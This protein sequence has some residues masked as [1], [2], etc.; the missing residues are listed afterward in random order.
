MM[1]E[2]LKQNEG[3]ELLTLWRNW[4]GGISCSYTQKL[5]NAKDLILLSEDIAN[6]LFYQGLRRG[7]IVAL[8]LSNSVGFPVIL[9][10]T[11]MIGCNPLLLHVSTPKN[12]IEKLAKNIPIRWIIHD[13]FVG[14][15]RLNRSDFKKIGTIFLDSLE[16]V[17]F[18][19]SDSRDTSEHNIYAESVIFHPTSGTYGMPQICMRNQKVTIAEAENYTIT[20]K[21][22]NKIRI[23]ITTPLSHAYA[24][25][26][27]L[28]S[29]IL[30]HSIL[31]VS[32]EFNPK[33]LLRWERE[34]P[35]DFLTIVPSMIKSLIYLKKFDS[36][37]QLPKVVFYAGTRCDESII[38]DFEQ[39]FGSTLYTIYGSTETGAI[40]TNKIDN[41][42]RFGVGTVLNNVQVK[43]LNIKKY[44]DLGKEIGEIYVKSSSMMQGYIHNTSYNDIKYFPT[45]DIGYL[46]SNQNVHL[47]GRIRDVINI[48]GIK[49]DPVEIENVLFTYPNIIDCAVYPGKSKAG[50]EIILAALTTDKEELDLEDVKKFCYQ[51]LNTHKIPSTFFI[52]KEIPRTASGK[53]L[54]INLPG[55]SKI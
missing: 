8:L 19:V 5:W 22:Y 13:F 23:H 21:D 34:N 33:M 17:V 52:L 35:S 4:Q 51:Y 24:Y 40:T 53:C 42:K 25:G 45:G 7:D 30:T 36:S 2:M 50:D 29:S 14:L 37:Y 41:N 15:S 6:K 46:D 3:S 26:F 16:I 44:F 1:K 31:V 10:A 47:V 48:G 39:L 11:L 54:K 28:V 55:D 18:S 27:G 12:E 20:I 38:A 43:I 49:I 32:P 9:L